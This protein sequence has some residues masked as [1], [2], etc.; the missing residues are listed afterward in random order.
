MK[1]ISQLRLV[2]VGLLALGAIAPGGLNGV[3]IGVCEVERDAN[4]GNA[5]GTSPLV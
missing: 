3:K 2:A 5:R 1:R 4:D